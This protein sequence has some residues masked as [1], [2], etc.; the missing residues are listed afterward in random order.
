M[1]G[2]WV[3]TSTILTR[4]E[5]HD[6]PVWSMFVDRFRR[7]IL[8]FARDAGL[9]GDAAEDVAQETLLAFTEAFRAGKY[10]RAEG[11]LSSWL[12]G[13]ANN[14]VREERR[15]AARPDRSPG[16]PDGADRIASIPWDDARAASRWEDAWRRE[17]LAICLE[18]V[19]EEVEDNTYLAFEAHA[20]RNQPAD[21]VAHDLGIARS[22]VFVAKHRV[23]TRIRELR[24]DYE[25]VEL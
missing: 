3:T 2:E 10:V 4:L 20:L 11:R 24:R 22:T 15:R 9:G 13:I 14:K 8:A 23:L 1:L 21:A 18:R 25:R 19:R 17:V 7:P 16:E 12:F 6:D 5:R